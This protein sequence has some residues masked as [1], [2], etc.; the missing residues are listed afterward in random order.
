M[1]HCKF[2]LNV[3]QHLALSHYGTVVDQICTISLDLQY[4]TRL[5]P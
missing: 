5:V 1:S 4:S 3:L 2:G